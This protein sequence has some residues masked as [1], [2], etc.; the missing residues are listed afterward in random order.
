MQLAAYATSF[1]LTNIS[2]PLFFSNW[3]RH[4]LVFCIL[5]LYFGQN[6]D[7]CYITLIMSIEQR[8]L[9]QSWTVIFRNVPVSDSTTCTGLKI[10]AAGGRIVAYKEKIRQYDWLGKSKIFLIFHFPH[11]TAVEINYKI[12]ELL[13]T[14]ITADC[15]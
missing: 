13:R 12:W 9:E 10:K 8:V 2:N 14:K 6:S 11:L 5:L 15:T 7:L 4:P 3:K 1:R